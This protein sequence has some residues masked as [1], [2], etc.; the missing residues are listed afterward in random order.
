[1]YLLKAKA[2]VDKEAKA[3]RRAERRKIR[4]EKRK[5]EQLDS[6]D[7]HTRRWRDASFNCGYLGSFE[8]PES[9]LT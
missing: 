1:M 8:V 4:L 9:L 6:Y 2:K 7:D 5:G 3:K